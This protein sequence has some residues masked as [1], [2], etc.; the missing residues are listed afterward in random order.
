M[1]II[2]CRFQFKFPA[3]EFLKIPKSKTTFP[4]L[5]KAPRG[6]FGVK[7][8]TPNT[9]SNPKLGLQIEDERKPAQWRAL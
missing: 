3:S 1:I 8:E 9:P 7:I 5:K 2:P 6:N 4:V